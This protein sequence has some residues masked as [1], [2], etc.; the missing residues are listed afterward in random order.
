MY[1]MNTLIF[2]VCYLIKKLNNN[3]P[4]TMFHAQCS[5]HNVPCTMF[6]AQCSMH[7]VPCTM[8]HAQCSMLPTVHSAGRGE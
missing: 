6:H 4:C 3:V 7:N 1:A 2:Q 8:F 5:M